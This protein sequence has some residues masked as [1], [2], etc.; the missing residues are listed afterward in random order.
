[1]SRLSNLSIA[2]IG[3]RV[4]TGI[5]FMRTE[6]ASVD[7]SPLLDFNDQSQLACSFAPLGA[8][9]LRCTLCHVPI[10]QGPATL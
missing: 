4:S 5:H 10:S 8:T 7:E 1:M 6:R 2:S 9:F 3:I